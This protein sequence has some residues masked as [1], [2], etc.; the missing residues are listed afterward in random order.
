M[1]STSSWTFNKLA[2][3]LLLLLL[4]GG[5]RLRLFNAA[6]A[7]HGSASSFVSCSSSLS[8]RLHQYRKGIILGRRVVVVVVRCAMIRRRI[9]ARAIIPSFHTT[10][11][12]LRVQSIGNTTTV[13][14][15]HS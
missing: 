5:I 9:I 4:F 13:H 10:N 12:R 1:A 8:S 7:V 14:V 15:E 6:A 3:A 2:F 11:K